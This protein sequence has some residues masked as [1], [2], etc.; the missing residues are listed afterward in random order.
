MRRTWLRRSRSVGTTSERPR[1]ALHVVLRGLCGGFCGVLGP[2]PSLATSPICPFPNLLPNVGPP[3]LNNS[4]VGFSVRVG[5]VGW[6]LAFG[7]VGWLSAFRGRARGA[8]MSC[9]LSL[10]SHQ[11]CPGERNAVN[12]GFGRWFV[13]FYFTF[14]SFY[15]APKFAS[16]ISNYPY[17][18]LVGMSLSTT[19]WVRHC[20]LH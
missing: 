18:D 14:P 2:T 9:S 10:R 3:L 11:F 20:L 4:L 19:L 17:M 1:G 8:K 7:L 12:H 15:S 5:W 16:E 6:V 13:L